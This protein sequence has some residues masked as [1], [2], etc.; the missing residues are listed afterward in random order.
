MNKSRELP[1]SK[2]LP[3]L[4]TE[5]VRLLLQVGER[6]LADKVPCLHIVDRCRCE[7]EFCGSFYTAPKPSGSYGP[8]HRNVGLS[9]DKGMLILDVVNEEIHH[10]EV[11]DRDEILAALRSAIP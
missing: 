7:D 1:L 9:P 6:D 2:V 4:S 5:L 8:G 3:E 11:L 10:V